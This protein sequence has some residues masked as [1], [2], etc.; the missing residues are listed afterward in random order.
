MPP[1]QAGD[2]GRHYPLWVVQE[3]SPA[4]P[5][6]Q[7]GK[8]FLQRAVVE[9]ACWRRLHL[10]AWCLIPVELF[11]R[12]PNFSNFFGS[13]QNGAASGLPRV[14]FYFVNS[15]GPNRAEQIANTNRTQIS[16]ARSGLVREAFLA[17]CMSI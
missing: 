8:T 10:S 9:L 16:Q 17:G 2:S 12:S 7:L 3:Q 6:E 1:A 14:N 11:S 15:I 5:Q 4:C 13:I